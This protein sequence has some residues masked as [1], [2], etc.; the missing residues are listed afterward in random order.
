MTN[1]ANVLFQNGYVFGGTAEAPTLDLVQVQNYGGAE[2]RKYIRGVV[3]GEISIDRFSPE[4]IRAQAIAAST[5]ALG[6]S[7][8]TNGAHLT[9]SKEWVRFNVVSGQSLPTIVDNTAFQAFLNPELLKVTSYPGTNISVPSGVRRANLGTYSVLTSVVDSVVNSMVAFS[10]ARV[11]VEFFSNTNYK[12]PVDELFRGFTRNSEETTATIYSRHLRM[13][14]SP[15]G[16]FIRAGEPDSGHGRGMS[17]E[18]ANDLASDT[19]KPHSAAEILEHYYGPAA[20]ILRSASLIQDG[21]EKYHV[22]WLDRPNGLTSTS[23]N[24]GDF[25]YRAVTRDRAIV[26]DD[27]MY[28]VS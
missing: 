5:F 7:G 19:L 24:L 12:S 8:V 13:A 4:A 26:L 1:S 18:G 23:E 21:E 25:R 9:G 20:P 14:P 6:F 10:G 28:V 11:G 16:D 3:L 2:F 15:D 27:S 22:A 17:Q